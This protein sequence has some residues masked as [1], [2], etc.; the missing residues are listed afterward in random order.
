MFPA[1]AQTSIAKPCPAA[2]VV[3]SWPLP[4]AQ[5]PRPT[6]AMQTAEMDAAARYL[7]GMVSG[8]GLAPDTQDGMYRSLTHQVRARLSSRPQPRVAAA[9][10]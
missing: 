1:V 4:G 3:S 9:L 8:L 6:M 2:N 5:V 10:A 7:V